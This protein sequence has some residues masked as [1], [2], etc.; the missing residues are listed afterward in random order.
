[1]NHEIEKSYES[2]GQQS[3]VI[4]AHHLG[5]F[6]QLLRRVGATGG[7]LNP[8]SPINLAEQGMPSK[9]L[10]RD[11]YVLDKYGST[12]E[13]TDKKVKHDRETFEKFLAL[14]DDHPVEIIEGGLPD[15]ICKGCIVGEHC[16]KSPRGESLKISLIG[17]FIKYYHVRRF[18]LGTDQVDFDLFLIGMK[19][20][21]L[22]KPSITTDV[23]RY[24]DSKKSLKARKLRTTIKATKDVLSKTGIIFK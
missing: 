1:M 5:L 9:S 24:S 6:K 17:K 12:S 19:K 18:P 4:R 22:P 8:T 14:P 7:I 16:R 20:L 10:K 21:N 13:S 11:Y 15:E 3:F 2:N 23:V